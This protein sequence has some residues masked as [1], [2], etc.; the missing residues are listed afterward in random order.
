MLS[1]KISASDWDAEVYEIAC[2]S[3]HRAQLRKAS[4]FVVDQI[5]KRNPELVFQWESN[6]FSWIMDDSSDQEYLIKLYRHMF[7]EFHLVILVF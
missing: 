3:A 4:A 7:N 5:G 1:Q 2:S 6:I